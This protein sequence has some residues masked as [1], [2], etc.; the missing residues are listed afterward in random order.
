VPRRPDRYSAVMDTI[1]IQGLGV[2]AVIGVHDWERGVT[3]TLVFSVDMGSSAVTSRPRGWRALSAARSACGSAAASSS[4]PTH[5]VSTVPGFT[6]LTLIPSATW[7]AA[8]ASV[9]A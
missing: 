4:R 1:S 7:W 5:G 8:T 9:S 2:P 3:Q 6:Q